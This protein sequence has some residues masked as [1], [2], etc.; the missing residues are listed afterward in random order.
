MHHLGIGATHARTPVLALVDDT[1]ITVI[2]LKTGESSP[3][4]LD[5]TKRYWR[6]QQKSPGRW[7]GPS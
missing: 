2:D 3:P 1:T 5:P 4:T 7:P 6:N